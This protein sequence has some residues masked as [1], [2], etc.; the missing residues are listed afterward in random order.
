MDT[1]FD[2]FHWSV[3]T[4]FVRLPE[5]TGGHI[6]Y[7]HVRAVGGLEAT[8]YFISLFI[9]GPRL[10]FNMFLAILIKDFDEDSKK[11]VNVT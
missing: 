11:V 8:L 5:D 9:V 7:Q 4:V 3:T 1:N 10:L 2:T 6:F